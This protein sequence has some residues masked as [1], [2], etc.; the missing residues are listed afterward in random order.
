MI[1]RHHTIRLTLL[2]LA[3]WTLPGQ[4]FDH[5]AWDRVLKAHVNPIGEVD[6]AA[7]KASRADL[8]RYI[9][10]LADASPVN[11]PQLFPARAHHLAYWI[12]AYN[13]FVTKGVVDSWPTKS[14]RNLGALYGFFRRKDYTAGGVRISLLHLEDEILRKQLPDPRI[15]F[16]IVCAS[17]SCPYLA[18]DAYTA[19]RLDQ[20]LDQAARL[21]V[22]QRRNFTPDPARNTLTLGAVY[23]LRDYV[24]DFEAVAGPGKFLDYLRRYLT[25]ENRRAL[26]ALKNPKVKFYDYDWSINDPGAR[27]RSTNPLER[28]LARPS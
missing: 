24:K 19:D 22:N 1:T 9:A 8:D 21:Y 27:L 17:L 20:Q 16:A 14:V 12:N 7:V 3:A 11:R 5:S 28:D 10:Q 15:H 4:S 25:D 13:A 26:D 18:P 2:A 6:Y 23:G